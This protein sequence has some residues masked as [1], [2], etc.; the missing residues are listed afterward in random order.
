MNKDNINTSITEHVSLARFRR[1]FTDWVRNWVISLFSNIVTTYDYSA[2]EPSVTVE[3]VDGRFYFTFRGLKGE[4]GASVNIKPSANDCT[5]VGDA[6]IDS[7]TGIIWVLVDNSDLSDPQFQ[8]AGVIKG[9]DGSIWYT[10]STMTGQTCYIPYN[11]DNTNYRTVDY[12]LNVL[13]GDVYK[14]VS[15]ASGAG[16]SSTWTHVGNIKGASGGKWYSSR[17]TSCLLS[18]STTNPVV[19]PSGTYAE[20]D[21]YLNTYNS[22]VYRCTQGGSSAMWLYQ[23]NIKGA[24]G[25]PGSPGSPGSPGA[26]G[27]DGTIVSKAY[28]FT[29]GVNSTVRSG[30]YPHSAAYRNSLEGLGDARITINEKDDYADVHLTMMVPMDK[31]DWSELMM[32]V[33]Q[34][35]ARTTGS[36]WV[37]YIQGELMNKGVGAGIYGLE[38]AYN[39]KRLWYGSIHIHHEMNWKEDSGY[40]EDTPILIDLHGTLPTKTDYDSLFSDG[41]YFSINLE[42]TL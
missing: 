17:E 4:K 11:E 39:E 5:Q 40:V 36:T 27:R 1:R 22:N 37:G 14:C 8:K 18:T 21:Y 30:A 7:S 41:M 6:Y 31:I 26:P 10:N 32:Y 19:G 9:A 28:R 35:G 23:C 24:P 3:F 25:G 38:K 2:G 16:T 29:V 33:P 13:T 20:G 15:P 42:S 34:T 12:H